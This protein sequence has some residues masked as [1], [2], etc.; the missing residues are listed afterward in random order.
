M[1]ISRASTGPRTARGRANATRNALSHGLSLPISSDPASPKEAD[2]LARKIVETDANVEVQELAHRVA[3]AQIDLRRVRS[4][5]H[6]LLSDALRNPDYQSEAIQRKK[7]AAVIRCARVFG[8]LA[9]M[10]DD[11]VEFLYSKLAG[12]HKFVA[13]LADKARQL[14]ALERYERRAPR[15]E[16][17]PFAPWKDHKKYS[18]IGHLG[19]T[20]P[21][22]SILS[23]GSHCRHARCDGTAI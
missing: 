2:A 5:R 4:A 18:Y 3:E 21:K 8:A 17:S 14:L 13:I 20:K 12:P 11:V 22:K 16:N 10:P 19:K 7:L 9:P 6:H 15:D 1:E 23:E